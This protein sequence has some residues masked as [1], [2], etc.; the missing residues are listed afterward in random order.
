VQDDLSLENDGHLDN[1]IGDEID[2]VVAQIKRL[3]R[4]A[5]L[6]FSLRVGAVIIHH[7]YGGDTDSWRSRGPKISSFRRLSQHPD[8]PLSAGALYRCVA[9]F[10]LCDRLNAPTRWEH[11]GASH[12]RLVLGL[13]ADTQEKLLALA[14]ANRWTVKTFQREIVRERAVRVTSGGRR[15]EPSIIKSLKSVRRCLYDHRNVL[16]DMQAASREDI[17]SN[18]QLLE[19]MRLY[20]ERLS[21]FLRATLDE[22]RHRGSGRKDS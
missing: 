11:L 15:A 7:F 20:V 22:S 8:L 10:E 13:P 16:E 5:N 9:L 12:L 21:A 3:A 4:T 1:E 17:E 6:E 2:I 19:E 14:N 18:V